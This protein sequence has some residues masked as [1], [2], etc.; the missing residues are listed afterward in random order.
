MQSNTNKTARRGTSL[1]LLLAL[2]MAA[3]I[4]Y[5]YP[6][7]STSHYKYK[8]GQAWNYAKL[9]APYDIDIYPDS[10]TVTAKID[11]IKASHIPIYRH[12]N[13]NV[14]SV[15]ELSAR[16]LHAVPDTVGMGRFFA[17]PELKPFVAQV[18]RILAGAYERGI[19]PDS[20]SDMAAHTGLH[21]IRVA[22]SPTEI[23][24]I[25]VDTLLTPI[26]VFNDLDRAAS[27]YNC[28]QVLINSGLNNTIT[29]SMTYD[30]D[31]NASIIDMAIAEAKAPRRRIVKDETIVD[32]GTVITPEIYNWLQNYERELSARNTLSS[33]S[34]FMMT[35]GQII[36]VLC[37]L[38]ALIGYI[39]IYEPRIWRT[40]KSMLFALSLIT[41][42]VVLEALLCYFV[43]SK[44]IYMAPL[45]IVPILV[46]VYLNARIALM[47][48]AVTTLLVAPL[49]TY[50]LEFIFIQFMAMAVAVYS[51]RDLTQRSQLLRTSAC[52]IGTGWVA[53][54]ALTVMV[55][56]SF[57]DFSWR[58]LAALTLSG[59]LTAMAYVLMSLIERMFGFIS[60]VTL[61]ELADTNNPLLRQ[62][63][64]ECP[65]TFQHSIAVSN[66]AAEAA[67]LIGANTLLTRAGALYHDIGKLKNPVFFTEN[68]HGVNPHDGLSPVKSAEIIIS[69]VPEGLK[70]AEKAGLPAVIRDFISQHH[71]AGQA[72]YFYYTYCKQHP[73]ENV[74]PAP[75]T[76]PGPNPRSREASVMMMADAVEAASRSLTEHT[77]QAI[78]ALVDKIIDSQIA[79]G[80]HNDST[81]S[82]KDVST[83]KDAFTRRLMTIYHSR[84]SYPEAPAKA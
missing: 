77:P 44:G 60:N 45:A 38:S 27:A 4:V 82:F 22:T 84:I 19:F 76:Y 68:Q 30:S 47:A 3:V 48:G 64:D 15:I 79:D 50:A 32:N 70:R 33:R 12:T 21:H 83:I 42:S 8:I 6:H 52:V 81:L 20:I 28:H 73:D 65:G 61:V 16:Q 54:T 72:K 43:P 17:Y 23:A 80:L 57:D 36:Y 24:K 29:P 53:Y 26:K 78:R 31:L 5:C 7:G 55:N 74:D 35:A 10:A 46:L 39:F 69:H 13:L 1:T 51:L 11:S 41:L 25:P 75:F 34:E 63:S 40:F 37:L 18:R 67:R 58:M 2:C 49:A 14:D 71:G 62:L 59:A 9:V 66:L 56:G